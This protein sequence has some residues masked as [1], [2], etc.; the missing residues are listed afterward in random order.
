VTSAQLRQWLNQQ[1]NRP[2]RVHSGR[3]DEHGRLPVGYR[4]RVRPPA[5]DEVRRRRVTANKTWALLRAA[6]NRAFND[7]KIAS[8]VAW[9]GIEK[10]KGVSTARGRFLSLDECQ[11]LLNAAQGGFRDLIR[12]ALLTGCRY[13]ELGSLTVG[14]FQADAKTIRIKQS[15]TGSPRYVV[16]TSEGV[17]FFS[18]LLTRSSNK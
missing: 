16:L 2:A 6:L 7:G 10:Y 11:R 9:R 3:L 1:G 13:S 18:Q 12:A 5:E 14:D 15:K 8:N 17:Q 4:Q